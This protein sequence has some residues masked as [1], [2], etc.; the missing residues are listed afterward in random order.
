MEKIDL[1]EMYKEIQI[2]MMSSL[3]LSSPIPN[4]T[5]KGDAT[6][7]DWINFFSKYLPKRYSVDR[8]IIIDSNGDTSKQ[9]DIIIYD[10][11]YS[12]FV[13]NKYNEKNKTLMIPAESVYAVFE[14]K[15]SLNN[16]N[17]EDAEEKAKSVRKLNRTS[18]PIRHAGGN[19]PPKKLHEISAGLLTTKFGWNSQIQDNVIEKLR[20]EGHDER[21]DLV[22]SIDCCTVSVNTNTFIVDY[23]KEKKY[24]IEFCDEEH[25]LIFLLLSL[26]KKLQDIGTAPAIDFEAYRKPIITNKIYFK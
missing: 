18:A 8:G 9:I 26:L 22:C 5:M 3:N 13:F 7:Y 25:S 12:Y 16:A 6:E 11:Q 14:V 15:Q 10:T 20:S 21:L 1:S 17:M 4:P 2:E 19:Y 23:K 24:D